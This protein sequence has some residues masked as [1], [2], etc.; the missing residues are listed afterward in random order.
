MTAFK[1][2]ILIIKTLMIFK[3]PPKEVF[4]EMKEKAIEVWKTY[5]NTFWYVDEKLERVNGLENVADNAMVFYRMFDWINQKKFEEWLS[6]ET[7]DYINNN[8]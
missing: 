4:Q 1:R 5:D 7:L 8:Q 6:S 3:A 2:I